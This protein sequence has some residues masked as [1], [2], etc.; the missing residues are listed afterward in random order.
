MSEQLPNYSRFVEV[1][2]DTGF[3]I[4]EIVERYSTGN[5]HPATISADFESHKKIS[6]EI[7]GVNYYLGLAKFGRIQGSYDQGEPTP[8]T[9]RLKEYQQEEI[10]TAFT[11]VDSIAKVER[12]DG[13]N[14]QD[15]A[16]KFVGEIVDKLHDIHDGLIVPAKVRSRDY[17]T[18]AEHRYLNRGVEGAAA[19]IL[20][21][22]AVAGYWY[23]SD[24]EVQ[25]S[26][27]SM[28]KP[29]IVS[30]NN[31]VRIAGHQ[32]RSERTSYPE[33]GDIAN[34]YGNTERTSLTVTNKP[35]EVLL[36]NPAGTGISTV[37]ESVH[38]KNKLS[39]GDHFNVWTDAPVRKS[40]ND[41]GVT[42]HFDTVKDLVNVCGPAQ[43]K[44]PTQVVLDI[45]RR[46]S[47]EH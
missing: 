15:E 18:P 29:T 16:E 8:W 20:A 25:S 31:T 13:H 36:Y 19:M 24:S 35:K 17:E 11:L 27:E 39:D 22:V 47:G 44:V 5:F 43:S 10:E 38:I 21:V 4:N 34:Q 33:V 37:C 9:V 45:S 7:Q 32:E 41:T 46:D 42:V 30:M 23:Y 26:L 40:S 6:L 1:G 12:N 2:A 14:T 28:G 3:I